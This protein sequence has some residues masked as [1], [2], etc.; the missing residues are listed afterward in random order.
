MAFLTLYDQV[1]GLSARQI[2]NAD[3]TDHW[4]CELRKSIVGAANLL[5]FTIMKARS[6]TL[7]A[8]VLPEV[9][10]ER[11]EGRKLAR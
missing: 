8:K 11:A 1:V 7:N 5:T 3:T 10:T 6:L 9:R 2:D 4:I